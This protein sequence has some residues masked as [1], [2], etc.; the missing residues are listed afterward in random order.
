MAR[1]AA[2]EAKDAARAMPV[3]PV[4]KLH[5]RRL[6]RLATPVLGLGIA[7]WI[8]VALLISPSGDSQ[9]DGPVAPSP[10]T[11]VV[12]TTVPQVTTTLP[13]VAP[14]LDASWVRGSATMILDDQ[15]SILY[16]Y[17][18]TI[19]YG[20]NTAWDGVDGFVA[21]TESGLIWMRPEGQVTIEAPFGSIIDVALSESGTHVVGID[22]VD[23]DEVVWIDLES[24]EETGPPSEAKTLD[25]VTFTVGDRTAT[26]EA[27]DWSDAEVD[28]IGQPLPPFD[29]PTLVVTEGGEEVLRME[30]GG[31]QLPYVNIH[32]FD[33]RRLIIGGEPFEPALPPVT[34]WIIDLECADCTQRIETDS[35]EYFDLIDVLA[36]ESPVVTPDLP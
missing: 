16:E 19:L 33:G 5:G 2:Q 24:G 15:G 12:P 17:P 23:G 9:P 25:G 29:L 30:V 14:P 31:D 18:T 10:S 28:E 20:R 21:L 35:L 27:P 3:V 32:D 13:E 11:T 36:S 6:A 26:I 1:E 34:A 8:I 7:V 22:P 4:E